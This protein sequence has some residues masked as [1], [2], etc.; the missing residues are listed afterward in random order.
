M[1]EE[2]FT[3]SFGREGE[4]AA[5]AAFFR[6]WGF[7]VMRDALTPDECHDTL[8]DVFGLVEDHSEATGGVEMSPDDRKLAECEDRS[9]DG[10]SRDRGPARV[11]FD[12]WRVETWGAFP[13]SRRTGMVQ[14]PPVFSRQFLRNRQNP[15]VLGALATA[16]GKPLDDVLVSHDRCT[17]F[18]PTRPA[19]T[20]EVGVDADVGVATHSDD[21]SG[22]GGGSGASG[23]RLPW[24]LAPKEP[25]PAWRTS[26]KNLHFDVNPREF[27]FEPELVWEAREQ[28]T[29]ERQ[30]EF[31][32]EN[33]MQ[34]STENGGVAVQGILNLVDNTDRDG[35]FVCVPTFH[36]H[37]AK[38]ASAGGGPESAPTGLP[39]YWFD[40]DSPV[41]QHARRIT[42]R[43]GSLIVFDSRLPH[44]SF[45]NDSSRCRCAQFIKV[46]ARASVPVSA[47]TSRAMKLRS[48]IHSY[49]PAF[50]T[51][52]I[53]PLGIRVFGLDA[54]G[55]AVG[56]PWPVLG[57]DKRYSVCDDSDEY[58]PGVAGAPAASA[59][60]D[61]TRSP[62]RPRRDA[63]T[64]AG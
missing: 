62:K 64:C 5:F 55:S 11:C 20:A 12:A 58:Q 6:R 9:A 40:A 54:V 16:L 43:A 45:P 29:Y 27:V 24:M 53:T 10:R 63:E 50:L 35:G 46:M 22:G 47:R 61:E 49:E 59:D 2:G 13:G 38:W 26:E 42:A 32:M 41:Y 28:L 25:R 51:E 56:R 31:I 4:A 57:A 39:L 30:K 33:N 8:A 37:F 19:A 15:F 18:R 36:K 52:D 60:D 21:G 23:R 48:L 7:A 14:K 34:T 3:Q 44:G 17:L 1:D